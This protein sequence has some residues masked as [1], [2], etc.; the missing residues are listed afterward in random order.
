ML[1]FSRASPLPFFLAPPFHSFLFPAGCLVPRSPVLLRVCGVASARSGFTVAGGAQVLCRNGPGRDV[2]RAG[3]LAIAHVR[4]S[5]S[6]GIVKVLQ[7]GVRPGASAAGVL[8]W[9]FAR[10]PAV[11]LAEPAAD[12]PRERERRACDRRMSSLVPRARRCPTK[13]GRLCTA[14]DIRARPLACTAMWYLLALGTQVGRDA[15]CAVCAPSR[16]LARGGDSAAA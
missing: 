16:L 14:L 1:V 6:P 5:A 11:Y 12:R 3:A 8:C 4:G 9:V 10:C 7:R 2:F 13:R 15:G